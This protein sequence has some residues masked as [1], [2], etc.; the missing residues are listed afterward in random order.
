[1]KIL[2]FTT[3]LHK[4][5][6][7]ERLSVE[8]SVEL[9]RLGYRADLL[10]LYANDIDGVSKAHEELVAFGVKEI[11]YLGLS[12]NPSF[13]SVLKSL[14]R[15][16]KLLLNKDYNAVEV[17]GFTPSLI[18]AIGSI[19]LKK[20][21]LVGLHEHYHK[22]RHSGFRYLIWRRVL[23]SSQR[24]RFYAISQSVATAWIIFS[25]TDFRRTSILYNSINNDYFNLV[26]LQNAR[27]A[28]RRNL[29]FIST[30]ILIVFVGRLV[31]SKGIDIVFD[32]VKQL[33]INNTNYH[34]LFVGREDDS[35]GPRDAIC[36]RNI[37]AEISD[38]KLGNRVHWLGDRLD[39]PK[40]MAACDLLVHP[41]RIEGFGLILAEALA[42][43]LPIVASNVGG[44]PEVL[45]GTDSLMVP[46]H[47]PCAFED[48]V[49]SVLARSQIIALQAINNGKNRAEA[50]RTEKR[51]RALVALLQS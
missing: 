51:A 7:R 33:L 29:E 27:D 18:A 21:I 44:I 41:A 5:G 46:K 28:T 25:N 37:K 47:D 1:M 43:G 16:R 2:I 35:E 26:P 30:D 11:H 45:A 10:S 17:S 14:F 50:F 19:G 36:L 4:V 24:V 9:N 20:K 12:I 49:G 39:V 6:G 42:V 34:L 3:T 23:A 38:A 22:S 8:M 31:I 48:A 40:I 15:F 13:I 32:A